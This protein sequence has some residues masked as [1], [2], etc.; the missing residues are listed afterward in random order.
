MDNKKYARVAEINRVEVSPC[1][2]PQ[3][4]TPTLLPSSDTPTH[5]WLLYRQDI[6]RYS[7][8]R[9]SRSAF[10][11]VLTEQGLWAL[12]QYRIA[13]AVYRSRLPSRIKNVLLVLAVLT[14]KWIEI[15]AG[16]TIPY[17]A[18]IGP[19][20]YIGHFGNIVLGTDIIMG[21]TCNISQGVTIG[22]SGRGEKRGVPHIGNRVYIAANAVV[23]GKITIGDDAVI[24]ANS[25]VTR[26]VAAHTT[27]MGVPASQ[28]NTHGSET[29]LNP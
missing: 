27:V 19:G 7:A 4:D 9:G 14:Q 28:I 24:A 5:W 22:V 2:H 16:I 20:L 26:D 25:L 3:G 6:A 23:V 18:L 12:C 1:V 10:S 29:Y 8:Y 21:H 13:S 11:I 15:V 17:Q